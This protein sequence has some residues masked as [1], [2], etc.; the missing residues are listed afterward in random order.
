MQS[1]NSTSVA[2]EQA[3][4]TINKS[5]NSVMSIK[6]TDNKRSQYLFL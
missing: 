6:N 5:F 2:T 3:P 1:V 4:V